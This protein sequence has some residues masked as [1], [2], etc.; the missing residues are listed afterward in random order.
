MSSS[1]SSPSNQGTE[2]MH[3]PSL[4]LSFSLKESYA[5]IFSHRLQEEITGRFQITFTQH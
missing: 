2:L 3:L 1:I 4:P 5:K